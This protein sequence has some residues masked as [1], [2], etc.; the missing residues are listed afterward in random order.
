M[1]REIKYNGEAYQGA[2]RKT[3]LH[4]SPVHQGI[5]SLQQLLAVFGH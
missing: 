2:G 1:R 5:P 4:P 3:F